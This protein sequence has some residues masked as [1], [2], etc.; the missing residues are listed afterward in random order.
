METRDMREGTIM[1]Y[2]EEDH[3]RLDEL[4]QEFRQMKHKD[5]TQAKPFFRQFVFGLQRHIIWE[6]EILFPLFEEK[7][8]IRQGGPTEA[9][10]AEHKQ[11]KRHL[12]LI[13]EKVRVH[14]P[15][16]DYEEDLL[17][18]AMTVHNLI[19]EKVLYPAIDRSLSDTERGKVF[20]SMENL[21]EN[22]YADCC[23]ATPKP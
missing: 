13:H 21:P 3:D 22:R 11:I 14:D 1:K 8:G 12:D 7:T 4:F 17:F 16:T 6:E 10:R 18:H 20:Q 2:Y 19:E 5:F 23:E 9:M 15:S